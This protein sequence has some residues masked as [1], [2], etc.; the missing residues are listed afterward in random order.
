MGVILSIYLLSELIDEVKREQ[1][2]SDEKLLYKKIN[3]RLST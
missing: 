3:D 2:L 1:H